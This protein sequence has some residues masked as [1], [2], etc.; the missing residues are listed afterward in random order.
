MTRIVSFVKPIKALIRRVVRVLFRQL[1]AA[2]QYAL[3]RDWYSRFEKHPQ[4]RSA[5]QDLHRI[6]ITGHA[7]IDVF[8]KK[9]PIGRVPAASVVIHNQ[10]VLRVDCFGPGKGHLHASLFQQVPA[11]ELRLFFPETTIREQIDRSVFEVTRNL[12]YYTQ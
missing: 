11:P 4:F 7:F 6:P 2:W 10:E 5:R 8:W 12:Y 3:R 1:S 9:L